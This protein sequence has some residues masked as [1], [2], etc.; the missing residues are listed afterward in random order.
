MI[1]GLEGWDDYVDRIGLFFFFVACA[2]VSLIVWAFNW[3]CWLNQ[4]CCCDFLH[5]P[6][7]KR[8]AWWMSFTFLCGMLACCIAGC[9]SVNRF[10]FAIEGTRCALDR[11]YYDSLNGQLKTTTP[12]WKGFNEANHL[13]NNLTEFIKKVKDFELWEGKIQISDP[14]VALNKCIVLSPIPN[15]YTIDE[16]ERYEEYVIRYKKIVSSLEY[17]QD[18]SSAL[19]SKLDS[20]TNTFNPNNRTEF[21]KIKQYLLNEHCF[22]YSSVLIACMKVLAM[23]YFCLFIITIT[24]AG[25]S[26]MFY[27]CLKRQGY[28]ITFMH[29]LWNIIRF[30]MFSF[31]IFGA[32]YGI[33]FLALKDSI[34]VVDNLFN[35]DGFLKAPQKNLF[36][37]QKND[38]FLIQ[39][40]KNPNYYF[41]DG[42]AD[43][44]SKPA[45][46][47]TA[48]E[49]FFVNYKEKGYDFDQSIKDCLSK[50]NITLTKIQNLC[51]S[52]V[53]CGYLTDL[54]EEEGGLFGS[55]N[56]GFIKTDLNLI[57]RALY[58]AS[59]ESRILAACSLCV[60]FFGAVAVYFYLLVL[61]HYNNELFFD[62]GKSIFTGFDGFGRGYKTKNH[63]QD[64]AYKKR[65]L[66]SEIELTSKNDEVSNYK[67]INKNDEED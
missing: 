32:A 27:A 67:D 60:S 51:E 2:G 57:Y 13:F 50:S 19:L 65:K 40:L 11:I 4:C 53:D 23:I 47:K 54:A 30:F 14:F 45:K 37:D 49:D 5:N 35:A 56:C 66:R 6:V 1:N 63:N 61:H 18:S 42:L 9:V 7:N 38:Q 31:F 15:T 34:A 55:L 36:P 39:C 41:K 33:F 16:D 25:I 52:P 10:G 12:K 3:V 59:V 20:L 29:V 44:Q 24:L 26:M 28:L 46:L 21:G 62:S 17:L 64:P 8:I 22:Y 48:F 58:D 43:G